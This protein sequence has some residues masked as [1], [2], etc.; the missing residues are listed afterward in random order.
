MK[1][2]SLHI[3]QHRTGGMVTFGIRK[4]R[5]DRRLEISILRTVLV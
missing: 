4:T 2:A 1:K 3:I 5:I